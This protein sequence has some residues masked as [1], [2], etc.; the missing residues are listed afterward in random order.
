MSCKK[1]L[2]VKYIKKQEEDYSEGVY[3][4]D[5]EILL[6]DRVALAP[7]YFQMLFSMAFKTAFAPSRI[8]CFLGSFFPLEIFLINHLILLCLFTFV[9][10]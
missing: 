2:N 5:N 3:E 8:T 6:W 7:D 1:L 10:L 9:L 4:I